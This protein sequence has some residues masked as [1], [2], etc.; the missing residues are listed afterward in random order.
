M[1]QLGF[2]LTLPVLV[3]LSLERGIVRALGA[4]VEMVVTGG[5]L[6]F[7]FGVKTKAYYFTRTLLSGGAKYL[8]TG[9][10]RRGPDPARR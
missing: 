7:L 3:S 10:V 1:G 6:F 8:A 2:L 4:V 9:C 5:V